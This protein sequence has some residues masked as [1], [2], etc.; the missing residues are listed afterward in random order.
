MGRRNFFISSLL[1][2][3]RCWRCCYCIY[4]FILLS[5]I[6]R[7]FVIKSSGFFSRIIYFKLFSF[8]YF[9]KFFLER[10]RTNSVRVYFFFIPNSLASNSSFSSMKLIF[11]VCSGVPLK[12][13]FEESPNF[14]LTILI[15]RSY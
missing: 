8:S 12:E 5:F 10:S 14:C 1:S 13:F 7:I 15:L 4:R 11:G 9:Y 6:I 3:I 2:K